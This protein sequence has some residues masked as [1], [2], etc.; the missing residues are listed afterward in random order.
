MSLL[1]S[2]D[3]LD[4]RVP[5]SWNISQIFVIIVWSSLCFW[6]LI[7]VIIGEMDKGDLLGI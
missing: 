1:V 6:I 2:L 3:E 7:L 4:S 5:R